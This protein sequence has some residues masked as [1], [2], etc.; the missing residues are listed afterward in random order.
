MQNLT[1]TRFGVS[2]GQEGAADLGAADFTTAKNSGK[3]EL[4]QGS[5]QN[6]AGSVAQG[7]AANSVFS[8]VRAVF[9]LSRARVSSLSLSL[10]LS[11]SLFG[12]F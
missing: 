12:A 2:R 8:G 4:L 3:I 6:K 5:A 9:A 1:F 10:S 7:K 11:R